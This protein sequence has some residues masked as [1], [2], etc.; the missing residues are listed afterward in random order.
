[1]T[2]S[3]SDVEKKNSKDS[4][5]NALWGS[6]LAR[7]FPNDYVSDSFEDFSEEENKNIIDTNLPKN[8]IVEAESINDDNFVA[9]ICE[10]AKSKFVLHE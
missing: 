10:L 8:K 4:N 6:D 3:K 9:P 1:L 5:K 7:I 2:S